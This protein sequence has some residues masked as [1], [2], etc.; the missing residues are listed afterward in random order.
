MMQDGLGQ[1]VQDSYMNDDLE[2]IGAQF[3]DLIAEALSRKYGCVY[4]PA[5]PQLLE[6]NTL[7]RWKLVGFIGRYTST[8][9]YPPA[10]LS[11][12]VYRLMDTVLQL[13]YI[14]EVDLGIYNKLYY[15]DPSYSDHEI[16]PPDLLLRRLSFDQ[17]LIGKSRVLWERLMQAIYFLEHGKPIEGKSVKG[18]F[19]AWVRTEPKWLFLEPYERVVEEF[20]SKF[21]TPEFHKGSILLK[22]LMGNAP[23]S[24]ND[25][26]ELVNRAMN[27][28]WEN[29]LSIVG[30]ETARVFTD[31]HATGPVEL[32]INPKFLP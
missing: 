1:L 15:D 5:A 13:Y 31:L 11:G 19:F 22:E 6:H 27:T 32:G 2:A 3:D 20:D 29:L 16:L 18:R 12:T 23:T 9:I 8:G 25:L 10:N 14:L 28:I 26:L 24:P 30:G 4:G 7:L 17:N 21:R